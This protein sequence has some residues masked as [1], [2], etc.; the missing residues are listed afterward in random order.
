MNN[1]LKN[2]SNLLYQ[3]KTAGSLSTISKNQRNLPT[4]RYPKKFGYKTTV[5][6]KI[7]NLPNYKIATLGAFNRLKRFR[8]E[9]QIKSPPIRAFRN[10]F[11]FRYVTSKEILET[12]RQLNG[13]KLLAPSR[14][15]GWALRH[16][17]PCIHIPLSFILNNANEM[18]K[19]PKD[20]K[21]AK[22]KPIFEKGEKIEPID[23]GRNSVTP[24]LAKVTNAKLID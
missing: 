10:S 16:A 14:V 8:H 21:K 24:G 4:S 1:I 18:Q 23:Y 15:P 20:L 9:K 11:D 5:H 6:C 17:A 2:F 12:L 19:F 22:F 7:K 3:R 13:K